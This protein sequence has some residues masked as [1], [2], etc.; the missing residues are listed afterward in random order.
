MKKCE[1]KGCKLPVIA[2]GL[3]KHHYFRAWKYG[4]KGADRIRPMSE[5]QKLSYP[6]HL[7]IKKKRRKG[8]LLRELAEEYHVS[9][10]RIHMIVGPKA[11]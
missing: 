6:D 5:I 7:N 1:I 11:A 8:A 9:I 4:E 10:S 2:K 3:C